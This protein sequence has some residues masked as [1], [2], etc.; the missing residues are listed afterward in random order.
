MFDLGPEKL[1][2]VM[3]AAFVILGPKELP[4]V[5]RTLGRWAQTLRSLRAELEDGITNTLHDEGAQPG[6]GNGSF[7]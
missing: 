5:A 3:A 6:P 2:I 4:T 1:I 7:N